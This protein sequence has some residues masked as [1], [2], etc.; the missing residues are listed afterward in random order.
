[1]GMYVCEGFFF[2]LDKSHTYTHT[3]AHIHTHL[4]GRKA[5]IP[6]LNHAA[7]A[8]RKLERLIPNIFWHLCVCVCVCIGEQ[9]IM[10]DGTIFTHTHT[11]LHTRTHTYLSRLESNLAP[12]ASRVPV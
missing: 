8:Q 2:W 6:A 5:F 4:H 9:K 7:V 10:N 1:M 12:S 3:H 11:Y